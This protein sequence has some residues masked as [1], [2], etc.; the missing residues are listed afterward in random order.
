MIT[1]QAAIRAHVR[2]VRTGVGR[3]IHSA[4]LKCV[5]APRPGKF[6]TSIFCTGIVHYVIDHASFTSVYPR[7]TK[8]SPLTRKCVR[9]V[10]VAG[11]RSS[12]A[13]VNDV[14]GPFIYY[15]GP[16]VATRAAPGL[17][18]LF[19]AFHVA[20]R[21]E[22]VSLLGHGIQHEVVADD[23]HGRTTSGN[24]MVEKIDRLIAPADPVLL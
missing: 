15:D 8:Y 18:S 11:A 1:R 12:A 20:D 14:T 24:V 10:C 17:A 6:S 9:A 19:A 23:E 22:Q 3:N 4:R 21:F 13:V 16:D 7:G 5:R 2:R